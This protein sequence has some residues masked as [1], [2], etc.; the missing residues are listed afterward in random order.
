MIVL[1][2]LLVAVGLVVAI[3]GVRLFRLLLP[4]IGL[5]A[6]AMVGFIGTEAVFGTGAVGVAM[7]LVAALIVGTLFALLSFVFFDFAVL[8]YLAVL[9]AGISAYLG[10]SLGLQEEGVLVFLLSAAGAILT[11]SWASRTG[12]SL[13]IVTI[14]T[15]F[16][17]VAY[18]LVGI[19]LLSGKIDFDTLSDQGVARSIISVVDQS[20][21]WLLVWLGASLLACQIQ[22]KALFDNLLT[23]TF[24]YTNKKA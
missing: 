10:V 16:I 14:F 8:V 21:I 24:E 17:G 22:I 20:F 1:G 7:A 4:V 12:V 11:V 9:G 18:T 19:F 15:S 13:S 23:K 3:L 2:V 6:G 5:A